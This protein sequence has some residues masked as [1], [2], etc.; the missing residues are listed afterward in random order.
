MLFFS[1]LLKTKTILKA[2]NIQ[3]FYFLQTKLIKTNFTNLNLS[4]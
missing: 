4:D 1:K 2:E 3:I